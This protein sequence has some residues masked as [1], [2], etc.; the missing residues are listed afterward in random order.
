MIIGLIALDV[1]G[2]WDCMGTTKPA[3]TLL[4]LAWAGPAGEQHAMPVCKEQDLPWNRAGDDDDP[5]SMAAFMPA[6]VV[7]WL[8]LIG[9]SLAISMGWV[10]RARG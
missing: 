6:P 9:F 5:L 10:R 7:L 2:L 3:A 4:S 1:S 8:F